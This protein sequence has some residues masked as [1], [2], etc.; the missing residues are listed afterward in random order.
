MRI[1]HLVLFRFTCITVF[2]FDMDF[3]SPFISR[4][5]HMACLVPFLFT[6]F[7]PLTYIH[8]VKCIVVVLQLCFVHIKRYRLYVTSRRNEDL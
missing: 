6:I 2:S 5:D 3:H 8:K 4:L 7:H 1:L